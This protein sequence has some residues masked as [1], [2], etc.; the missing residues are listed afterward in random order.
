ME[1]DSKPP[2]TFG[3]EKNAASKRVFPSITSSMGAQK[4]QLH[5]RNRIIGNNFS[6]SRL[7]HRQSLVSSGIGVARRLNSQKRRENSSR[8]DRERSD[9]L[10][11]SELSQISHSLGAFIKRRS[12]PTM[13]RRRIL[14]GPEGKPPREECGPFVWLSSSQL[15]SRGEIKAMNGAENPLDDEYN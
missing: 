4:P 10:A 7:A 15:A 14:V 11:R 1:G 9:R 2:S 12:E 8:P 6:R 13:R 3:D 5:I